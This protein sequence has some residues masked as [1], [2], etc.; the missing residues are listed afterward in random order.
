[1]IYEIGSDEENNDN[2]ITAKLHNLYSSFN[3]TGMSKSLMMKWVGHTAYMT[4]MTN[5]DSNFSHKP[6]NKITPRMLG[7]NRTEVKLMGI[8]F[9]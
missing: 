5:K 4:K 9:S 8:I 2:C 7:V 3:I 6:S 1:L